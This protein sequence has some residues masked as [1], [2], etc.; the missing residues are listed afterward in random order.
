MAAFQNPREAL[1]VYFS[2]RHPGQIRSGRTERI[3]E[4]R[5]SRADWVDVGVCLRAAGIEPGSYEEEALQ[6]WV[7]SDG[8]FPQKAY[9]RFLHQVDKMRE[10]RD[11]FVARRRPLAEV[12]RTMLP[13]GQGLRELPLDPRS[14]LHDEDCSVEEIEI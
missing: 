1:A 6:A 8:P 9:R 13:R 7:E 12:M 4:S 3:Q 2:S 10:Q 14:P 5:R 11:D